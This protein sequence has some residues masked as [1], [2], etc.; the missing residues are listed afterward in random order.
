M[1]VQFASHTPNEILEAAK[2]VENH[3]DAIDINLGCPQKCAQTYN[4]GAFLL[5]Q[6]ETVSSM[7]KLL[8]AN[9]KIPIFA[10]IRIL[11]TLDE[12]LKFVKMLENSGVSLITIHGRQK[13]KIHHSQPAD[14]NVIAEI[15]KHSTVPILSNGNVA[16]YSDVIRNLQIT[17]NPFFCFFCFFC[18]YFAHVLGLFS[19]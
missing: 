14:L 9:I 10:K 2:L 8:V 16:E 6:P 3:C 11:P 5:E 1:V 17:G 18:F 15:K 4:F 7:I 13:E 12:T 19:F